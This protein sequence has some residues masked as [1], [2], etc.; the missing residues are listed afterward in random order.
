[1]LDVAV[2]RKG[3]I[4]HWNPEDPDF[5]ESTGRRVA[6]RNLIFS[7]F[8]EH[9]GFSVWLL[10]SIVVVRLG[11]A[12]WDLSVSQTLW[13]T[14]VPS[15][16]GAFLRLPYTFAVPLFG[17]RNW[18]V[19][20]ALLLVVPCALLAWAVSDPTT[21]YTTLLL[22]ATT[23][24]VGGG[25]FAS[26]MT[27]ISF[28]YPEREKGW[29]LGLNAAGG[30]IG[31]AVVQK[32]V[33][34][35]VAIGG[36]LA[37]ARAGL[38][39]IPLVVIAAVCAFLFMDNLADA[40]S[41]VGATAAAAKRGQT[42][43]MSVLYIG[44]FGSFIG[45]SAAFPALIKAPK[46]F[47]NPEFAL[48]WGFLGA[49]VGS[50]ARP[51]GGRLSDRVGGAKVTAFAFAMMTVGAV[52]ALLSVQNKQFGLFIASFMVL[53]VATGLGNGST[54]RM[55]PAIFRR[56]GQDAGG[57]P[58]DLL[59]AKR[60]AAGAIGI[61]SA[62]GAFGGFLVPIAYAQS[63]K[64]LGSIEPALRFYVGFFVVMLAITWFCYL[65]RGSRMASIGA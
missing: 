45:Y 11:S 5:W 46:V 13:L 19:V 10:W 58:S 65:R 63:N 60:E 21:S 41:D 57:K 33:P 3:W 30:N 35:V 38:V 55:I 54:Y 7:I 32:L 1:M 44:T 61:T 48:T 20:S 51:L 62:V 31:V 9:I 25:N 50:V 15:G 49:L 39:Y 42:W 12:G 53:F 16:V 22:V 59:R 34:T 56:M 18:T 52:G 6:R 2:E 43:I 37:L 64:Q 40:K 26:S 29:A 27:N 24:G 28:F 8:A 4:S 23:A 47:D 14:A 36:G 17:G